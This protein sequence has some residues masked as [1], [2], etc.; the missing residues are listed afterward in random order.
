MTL[1]SFFQKSQHLHAKEGA[2]FGPDLSTDNLSSV[3][4][5][6]SPSQSCEKDSALGRP[7][8]DR[9]ILKILKI[10]AENVTQSFLM[11]LIKKYLELISKRHTK[12]AC[13]VLFLNKSE[14]FYPLNFYLP[15]VIC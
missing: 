13:F 10:I 7:E 3:P 4:N 12:S 6:P 9:S 14:D 2:E 1:V 8:M 15:E 11:Q 5:S